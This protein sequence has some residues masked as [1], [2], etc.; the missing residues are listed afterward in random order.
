MRNVL[1]RYNKKLSCAKAFV[2]FPKKWYIAKEVSGQDPDGKVPKTTQSILFASNFALP[3]CLNQERSQKREWFLFAKANSASLVVTA[4]KR[5]FFCQDL[6]L[7]T[8][9]VHQG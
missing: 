3:A 2:I 1:N 5:P 9:R 8:R 4:S 7:G 6:V